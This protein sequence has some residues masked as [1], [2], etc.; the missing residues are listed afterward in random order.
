M[1][2]PFPSNTSTLDV[3]R[4]PTSGPDLYARTNRADD[5]RRRLAR[6]R[7]PDSR[8]RG[9][10]DLV[11]GGKRLRPVRRLR[12][13]IQLWRREIGSREL[14]AGWADFSAADAAP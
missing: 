7:R 8:A 2:S 12:E 14:L 13:A 5:V 4:L 10:P 9:Y 1:R 11:G 3:P 6:P